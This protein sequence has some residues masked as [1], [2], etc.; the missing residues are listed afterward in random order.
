DTV[1]KGATA[2]GAK[3]TPPFI[4]ALASAVLKAASDK[5]LDE[6]EKD[7]AKFLAQKGEG[8]I[9]GNALRS[10]PAWVPVNR[11]KFDPKFKE[12]DKEAE[13]LLTRSFI[14]CLDL[15]IL[16]WNRWYNWNFH[17]RIDDGDGFQHVIGKGNSLNTNEKEDLGGAF[18][19]TTIEAFEML[20]DNGPFQNSFE[21]IM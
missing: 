7:L 11:K 6:Y 16:P 8:F 18:D 15:P 10:I 9:F 1:T 17:V 21:C 19:L 5:D 3:L 14:G 13:G 12:V 4:R 20:R 2:R